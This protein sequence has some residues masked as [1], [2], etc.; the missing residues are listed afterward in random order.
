MGDNV[1]DFFGGMAN[2]PGDADDELDLTELESLNEKSNQEDS[3]EKVDAV[4]A[5]SKDDDVEPAQDRPTKKIISNS[6]ED[7]SHWLDLASTLGIA[8]GSTQF[9][10]APEKPHKRSERK[11]PPSKKPRTEPRPP[12]PKAAR[13]DSG[14]GKG[15]LDEIDSPPEEVRQKQLLSELFVPTGEPIDDSDSQIRQVD[16]VEIIDEIEI[17]DDDMVEF[18]VEE[19][20]GEHEVSHREFGRR[21]S[22]K[23]RP[24]R[25]RGDEADSDSD[26]NE[27][28]RPSA[29]RQRDRDERPARRPRQ[30]ERST[31][32][33]SERSGERTNE[34]SSQRP[35]ERS[36][37]G[38][39][40]QRPTR[41]GERP[42]QRRPEKKLRSEVLPA[43][44]DFIIDPIDEDFEND[45]TTSLP[46]TGDTKSI[47][48]PTW[49]ETITPIIDGNIARRSTNKPGPRPRRPN[50]DRGSRD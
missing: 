16:D 1:F 44:E 9:E 35:S 39:S 17:L 15:L 38:R 42:A 49:Q 7:E 30:G 40:E 33:P 21:P 43:D 31:E 20:T 10:S 13:D 4:T 19:L 14:F 12:P 47:K 5:A 29:P 3:V 22:E 23:P 8:G 2:L 41:S 6:R 45:A 32:R 25:D 26:A 37:E 28:P 18:E 11:A 46:S 27:R 48:F 50:R 36:N 24:V 34:R